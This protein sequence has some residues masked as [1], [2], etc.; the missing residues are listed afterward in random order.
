MT[1]IVSGIVLVGN[2]LSITYTKTPI[3]GNIQNETDCNGL[4]TCEW[5]PDWVFLGFGVCRD[6]NESH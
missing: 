6:V 3:C 4:G 1:L 2:N 5:I